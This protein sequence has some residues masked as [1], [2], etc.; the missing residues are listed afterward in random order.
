L[1][2]EAAP[3]AMVLADA[4]GGIIL[5]NRQTEQ[6]FGYRRDELIG[7]RVEKLIENHTHHHLISAKNHHIQPGVVDFDLYGLRK[8]GSV[9][10]IEISLSPLELEDE[11]LVSVR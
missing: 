9:F 2:F 10:P 1:L 5:V 6:L 3:D 8:D 4:R 11:I 7:E